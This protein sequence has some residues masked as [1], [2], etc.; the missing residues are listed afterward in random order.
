M[1]ESSHHK[2][3]RCWKQLPDVGTHVEH[4]TLCGRCLEAVG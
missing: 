4:P 1:T 2:C 3:A